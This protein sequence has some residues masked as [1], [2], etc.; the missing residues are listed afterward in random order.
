[1]PYYVSQVGD[2]RRLL[3]VADSAVFSVATTHVEATL[4]ESEYI[5][6]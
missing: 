1:M 4:F 5:L 2:R 3:N 6:P